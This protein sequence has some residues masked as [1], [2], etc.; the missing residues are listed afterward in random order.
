MVRGRLASTRLP[1]WAIHVVVSF[2][3]S[4]RANGT[5]SPTGLAWMRSTEREYGSAGR[6]YLG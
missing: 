5:R 3:S 6:P 2:F 4:W 1:R